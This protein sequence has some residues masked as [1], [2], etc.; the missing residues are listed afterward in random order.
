MDGRFQDGWLNVIWKWNKSICAWEY[1]IR[2]GYRW[3]IV[4]VNDGGGWGWGVEGDRGGGVYCLL[5]VP[6]R[7]NCHVN[8]NFFSEH[9]PI[10]FCT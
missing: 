8:A 7:C 2:L 1:G 10:L 3:G 4:Q 5:E 9:F 6:E